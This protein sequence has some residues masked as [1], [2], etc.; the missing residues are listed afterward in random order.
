VTLA[1]DG[2]L[3]AGQPPAGPFVLEEATIGRIHAAFASGQLTCAQ[4]VQRYLSRIEG[5]DHQ[6]PAL[7]AILRVNPRALETAADMDRMD[8]GAR[9]QR[10]LHCVPVIVKD[11]YNTATCRPPAVR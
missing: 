7:N 10:P 3:S 1:G 8:A 6:G 9:A 11:N 4:L 5:Y 2:A